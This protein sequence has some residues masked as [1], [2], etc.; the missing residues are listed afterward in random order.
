M[1]SS[2]IAKNYLRQEKV[3]F[4]WKLPLLTNALVVRG[5]PKCP[6][7]QPQVAPRR[8]NSNINIDEYNV[9]RILARI[10]IPGCVIEK[11]THKINL[12]P[13]WIKT[14]FFII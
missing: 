11:V 4:E 3:Y 5:C 10:N 12:V 9:T 14:S 6:L 1:A 7:V 2:K 13:T 8:E